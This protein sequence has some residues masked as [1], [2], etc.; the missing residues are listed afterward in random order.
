MRPDPALRFAD[1]LAH[2]SR[3]M[4]AQSDAAIAQAAGRG[5]EAEQLNAFALRHFR[6][7]VGLDEEQL[8]LTLQLAWIYIE[9]RMYREAI[10][11]LEWARSRK[12]DAANVAILLGYAYQQAGESDKALAVYRRA[13]ELKPDAERVYNRA[14]LILFQQ[15]KPKEALALLAK[16]LRRV[17]EPRELLLFLDLQGRIAMGAGRIDPAISCFELIAGAQTNN[18][19]VRELLGGLY[20]ANEQPR[21]TIALLEPLV[22]DDP[23]EAAGLHYRLG[24]AYEMDG[25]RSMAERAFRRACE[26]EPPRHEPFLALA[27]LLLPEHPADAE[28]ALRDG[29]KRVAD[30][31]SLYTFLGLLFVRRDEYAR[32]VPEFANAVKC[33]NAY[34]ENRR[35]A[36]I[37][38]L[39]YW[40]GMALERSGRFDDA[41]RI[42]EQ[43]I[44][45]LPEMHASLN[46][47]AYMWA[48]KGTNLVRARE[49]VERALKL[50]PDNPAYI[51]TLGWILYRQ[52]DFAEA[53]RH[54]RRA[55]DLI[56]DD[57]T[58]L[59]H[60]GDVMRAL[61]RD[62]E[63]VKYWRA[64][65]LLQPENQTLVEKLS[66]VGVDVEKL[67]RKAKPQPRGQDAQKDGS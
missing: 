8:A 17:E 39:Y 37:P 67:R 26:G 25:D 34:P 9:S 10:D 50:E 20:N 58:V 18:L 2:F 43:H 51:D 64:S 29:L 35:A 6:S 36:A 27:A 33:L 54:L 11:L 62:P 1:A 41:V 28:R 63:A 4:I 42:F 48:E 60:R 53:E 47:L 14:A 55:G 46:Y 12:R 44:A 66:K 30:H 19:A 5:E 61:K 3:G 7:V 32:A 13:L 23:T 49:Y 38:M 65:F 40:Y 56:P 59:E 24:E 22:R 31:P 57:P 21:R 15:H 45:A 16:G 52:G